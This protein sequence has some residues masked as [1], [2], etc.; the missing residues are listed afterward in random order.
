M[1]GEVY[2]VNSIK[3]ILDE[4]E[5]FI[6]QATP[7][8]KSFHPDYEYALWEMLKNGGKRF[9]P[10]LL[11]LSILEFN[12]IKFQDEQQCL[13]IFNVALALECL[14]TYSLIHDDL[15]AMDNA[16]LR[17]SH[18]TLHIKYD[19]TLAILVGD[20]LNTYAFFLLSQNTFED[21]LKIQ[22]ISELS[23]NGGMH[24]MVLGQ[25]LDCHFE[26]IPLSLQELEFLHTRKTGMLIAS[27]LKMGAIIANVEPSLIKKLYTLG[28]R[29]GL[30]F[31]IYDD[32]IDATQESIQAGKTTNNDSHKNSYV[33]LLGLSQAQI[34]LNDMKKHFLEECKNTSTT[35]YDIFA[36][37]INSYFK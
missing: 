11:F 12:P 9:R 34:Y 25:A 21:S 1:N 35:F 4:F 8:V 23:Y 18:P 22:L 2:W 29:L 26:N 14:H 3:S 30:M 7:Q 33:N 32:I 15:P 28:L 6:Q 27:S 37:I 20:A 5:T 10:M 16:S 31:Q 13:N 24:G 19:E 36:N 17:R